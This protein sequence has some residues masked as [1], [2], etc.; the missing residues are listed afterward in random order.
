MTR[1]CDLDRDVALETGVSQAKVKLVTQVFLHKA[2]RA[3]IEG[4]EVT[5]D[6]FGRLRLALQG[7]APPPNP[8]IGVKDK[9]AEDAGLRWRVH[10][11]KSEP[12]KRAVK[13][14]VKESTRGQIRRRRDR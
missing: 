1:K 9:N 13:R 6:G 4:H 7:G 11:K 2:M 3:L 12:F 10:F 8:K 5:F 14:Y